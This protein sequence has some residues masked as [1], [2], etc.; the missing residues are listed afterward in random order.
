MKRV[1][2]VLIAAFFAV[3]AAGQALTP[4]SS[5]GTSVIACAG[6]PGNTTGA[7]R[8]QC[9]TAGGAIYACNNPSG[10]TVAADWIT[11]AG[12]VSS[13]NTNTGAVALF[14]TNPQTGTY[15]VLAADFASC[16]TIPIA[17]GTFTITLV[18]SGSQPPAGQCITVINYGSGTVTI[19]RSGQNING[20]TTSLSLQ[21]GSATA[22]TEAYIVS[23][24]T[25]Y[26][27]SVIGVASVAIDGGAAQTG[28]VALTSKVT[29]VNTSTGAVVLFNANAQTST[30]QAV[31]ADFSSC[32][33]IP[34]A[35]G[36]FTI[37]LVASG[38]PQPAGG[39]CITVINYGSGVVT[40]ARNGQNIN[41]GT[42][43][44]TLAAGSTTA[45]TW[46]YVVSDGTN[47]FASGLFNTSITINGVSCP[48]GGSCT[49][50]GTANGNIRE[51]GMHFDG[52]G[53]A[54]S[55]T[56]TY[57][58]LVRFAGTIAGWYV[59]TDVSGSAT[60]AVHSVAFASY[61]GT[62]GFAG[63][64]DVTGGGTAPSISSATN[65]TFANLTSWV[66]TVTAGSEFCFQM[67]SPST[68]TWT[69]V[70]LQVNT[71]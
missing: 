65:A 25:N 44:L 7:Y 22:P 55:G 11:A 52:G 34:V 45:P 5:G 37:T 43:S 47:Y 67:T 38:G 57:C 41:G 27:A 26:E 68:A 16:K 18:A 8:Q 36:T 66:T 28:A 49:P 9:Q 39:Q 63:Y 51:I 48:L 23:D 53:A 50:T 64:A 15:Q 31:A 70:Y 19:T 10:C 14:A 21:A 62:A 42:T 4:S 33:T 46:A 40:I 24:G 13:V 12:A 6:T 54:L 17:S 1:S 20:G 56:K 32:K 60:F 35:S 71:N 29:S 30:Y 58:T 61:T 59:D 69:N 3:M 2:V